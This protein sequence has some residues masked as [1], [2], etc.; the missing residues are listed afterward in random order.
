MESK[1][2]SKERV[3]AALQ[4]D[5]RPFVQKIYLTIYKKSQSSVV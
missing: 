5:I 2:D 1:D 4:E 3:T